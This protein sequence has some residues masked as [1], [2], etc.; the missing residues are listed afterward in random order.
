MRKAEC[1]WPDFFGGLGGSGIQCYLFHRQHGDGKFLGPF[2]SEPAFVAGLVGNYRALVECNNHPDYKALFYEKN[3]SLPSFKATG[4]HWRRGRSAEEHYGRGEYKSPRWSSGAIIWRRTG[5]LENSGWFPDF[6]EL[7]CASYPLIFQ[8]DEDWPW[9]VQEFI[10][11]W[12]AEMAVMQLIDKD[13]GIEVR[14]CFELNR[15]IFVTT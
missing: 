8:W 14:W 3:T 13:L 4:P 7:F 1:L 11:V 12:P 6:W 15:C 9:R 10:R 5:R 2:S